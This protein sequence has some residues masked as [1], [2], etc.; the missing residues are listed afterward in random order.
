MLKR[1]TTNK[2]PVGKTG[3]EPGSE[4]STNGYCKSIC[5]TWND[6]S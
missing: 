6:I 2:T 1:A 3:A 4:A 5:K